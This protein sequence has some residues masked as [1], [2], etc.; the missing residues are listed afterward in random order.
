MLAAAQM[1][2]DSIGLP[3]DADLR[4]P[5]TRRRFIR[6]LVSIQVS[7]TIRATEENLRAN[8]VETL[9]DLRALPH[10]VAGYSP[11]LAAANLE[12]KAYL[13][14]NFYR[15]FRVVRMAT[16]AERL[17]RALF[18]AYVSVPEQL[19]PEVQRRAETRASGLHRVICDYISGMTDRYAI[20]EHGRL[21]DPEERS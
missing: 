8:E 18:A 13:F 4:D 1:A 2:I 14:D 19:P 20:Q 9:A 7:E 5:L 12:L 15:H 10:N 3:A 17:I 6:R 16:K 11:A 21:Y